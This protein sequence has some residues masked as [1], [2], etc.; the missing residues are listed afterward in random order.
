M[1]KYKNKFL[2][3]LLI[4][5]LLCL[6]LLGC[7]W[8]NYSCNYSI[9]YADNYSITDMLSAQQ[10]VLGHTS[11]TEEALKKYDMNQ[12]GEITSVDVDIII[13]LLLGYYDAYEVRRNYIS[14][15]KYFN[16]WKEG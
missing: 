8:L 10:I 16:N 13:Q 4:I 11:T 1:C 7:R 2:F 5:I 3:F 9:K 6:I 12:D 15:I 14:S